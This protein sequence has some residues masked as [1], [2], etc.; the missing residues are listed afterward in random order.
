VGLSLPEQYIDDV[1]KGNIVVGEDIRLQCKRHTRQLDKVSFDSFPYFFDVDA[2]RRAI[3]F[4]GVCP[5]GKGRF[6]GKPFK[7]EGFQ[8]ALLW[9]VYGWKRKDTGNRKYKQVYFKVARKNGKTEFLSLIGN[10]G[11]TLE[12][13]K[14]QER[15]PEIYWA[16]TKKDQAKY[17]WTIQK[18]QLQY[19]INKSKKVANYAKILT[20]NIDTKK[21]TGFVRYLGKDSRTED[22]LSPY[23]GLIDEYHEHPT[24]EMVNVVVSGMGARLSPLLWIITTA[25]FNPQ[26]PCAKYEKR[27]KDI[28]K[29]TI[30]NENILPWIFDL[31]AGDDWNDKTKWPKANPNLGVS[32]SVEFL[33][34]QY[35]DAVTM[36][37]DKEVNFLTK[38]LNKWVNAKVT[39]IRDI[40]YSKNMGAID[41]DQLKGKIAFGGLDLASTDD[42]TSYCLFFPIQEGLDK[43][44][45]IWQ[46]F[47]PKDNMRERVRRDQVPYLDWIREGWISTTPG[48]V[49]DY[50]YIKAHI[51]KSF[52]LY[53]IRSIG[54]DRWNASQLVIDLIDEGLP[55]EKFG[56]GFGS[57][58]APTKEYQRL[59]LTGEV[60]V[61]DNPVSRWQNSNIAIKLDPAGNIKIDKAK[62][63]ERVD[64]MV[65]LVMAIGEKMDK[66]ND[67]GSVY[68]EREEGLIIL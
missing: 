68:D 33:D 9:Q 43:A 26:S 42:T 10:Y 63:A 58:N 18:A 38:N 46:Y 50:N 5:F 65:S 39:F 48:N 3:S 15:D 32:V 45:A 12:G 6:A 57:M 27:C 28:L 24:D 61:G 47:I 62:S 66:F 55:F 8:A 25:G 35:Q 40:T 52:E 2:A 41:L 17:G 14:A 60:V 22:G 20:H 31:D 53:N 23:Y 13:F 7:L 16:A 1:L 37:A 51:I 54:F 36:G 56:Q 21:G 4:A 67:G 19:L 59:M 49:T 34:S 11:F 30:K 29:G 44:V 64:G